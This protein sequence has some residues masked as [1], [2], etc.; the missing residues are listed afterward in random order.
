MNPS[1]EI[2][3]FN[4]LRHI[5]IYEN[6]ENLEIILKTGANPNFQNKVNKK[7]IIWVNL[8]IVLRYSNA[9]MRY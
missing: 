2:E 7:K 3:I 8:K 6:K 5:I 1:N 4:K 9:Y